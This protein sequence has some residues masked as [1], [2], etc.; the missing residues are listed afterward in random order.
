MW[1]AID[2]FLLFHSTTVHDQDQNMAM[3]MHM[4]QMKSKAQL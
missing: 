1:G 3:Y 2:P 4:F